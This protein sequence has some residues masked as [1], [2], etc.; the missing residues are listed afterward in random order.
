MP[1]LGKRMIS[2]QLFRMRLFLVSVRIKLNS[3]SSIYIHSIWAAH[4]F[5]SASCGRPRKNWNN[6]ERLGAGSYG[7][8]F[9]AGRETQ[10]ERRQGELE[11]GSEVA[12]KAGQLKTFWN[13]WKHSLS[14]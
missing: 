1:G 14:T 9:K 7:S 5:E 3:N 12:I 13:R 4:V 2:I 11:D 6:S 10:A 8:V